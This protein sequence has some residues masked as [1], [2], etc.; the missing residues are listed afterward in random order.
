MPTAGSAEARGSAQPE[1]TGAW[2][3]GAS[4]GPHIEFVMRPPFVLFL[5]TLPFSSALHAQ[6]PH[7]SIEFTADGHRIVIRTSCWPDQNGGTVPV[8]QRLQVTAD[9]YL[10]YDFHDQR[11]ETRAYHEA[12]CATSGMEPMRDGEALMVGNSSGWGCHRSHEYMPDAPL[13]EL[14]GSAGVVPLADCFIRDA[15]GR[16]K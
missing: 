15:P 10:R 2:K 12:L 14:D 4:A 16:T 11:A 9:G 13:P 3:L 7:D 5:T 8:Q 6:E 1:N